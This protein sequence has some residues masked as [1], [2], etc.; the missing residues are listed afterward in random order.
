MLPPLVARTSGSYVDLD[1]IGRKL[2]HDGL[3]SESCEF[4]LFIQLDWHV[5]RARNT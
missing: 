4:L 3:S 2:L 5:V 1:L